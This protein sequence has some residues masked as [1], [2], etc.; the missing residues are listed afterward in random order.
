MLL[1]QSSRRIST[2]GPVIASRRR[3]EDPPEADL[4]EMYEPWLQEDRAG[5][6]NVLLV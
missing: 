2:R 1:A 3:L 6:H 4:L 5:A